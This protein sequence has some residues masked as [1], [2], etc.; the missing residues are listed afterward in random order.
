MRVSISWVGCNYTSLLQLLNTVGGQINFL[1][2]LHSECNFQPVF[3]QQNVNSSSKLR[4]PI[5]GFFTLLAK[6]VVLSLR[7]VVCCCLESVLS[8]HGPDK[9]LLLVDIS[10]RISSSQLKELVHSVICQQVLRLCQTHRHKRQPSKKTKKTQRDETVG[11]D[12]AD[13]KGSVTPLSIY[14]GL[15]RLPAAGLVGLCWTGPLQ[16]LEADTD[17]RFCAVWLRIDP[18]AST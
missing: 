1:L 8:H 2:V 7:N 13:R 12:R 6:A 14:G 18:S 17:T 11:G 16:K 5:T 9:T 3:G 10:H 15:T 4:T